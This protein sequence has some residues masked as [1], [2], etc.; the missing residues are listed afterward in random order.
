M[1]ILNIMKRDRI[2]MNEVEQEVLDKVSSCLEVVDLFHEKTV[3]N[4]Y[5]EY[6][7]LK[8]YGVWTGGLPIYVVLPFY[9]QLI[10]HLDPI[11]D[12]EEFR[13]I[14]GV[15]IEEVAQLHES[16]RLI[17][18]LRRSYERY[19]EYYDILFKNHV[20]LNNRFEKVFFKKDCDRIEIY[21]EIVWRRFSQQDVPAVLQQKVE[22]NLGKEK[23]KDIILGTMAQRL[24]KLSALGFAGIGVQ[25]IKENNFLKAYEGLHK[26]NRAFAVPIID[27]LGGW[28]NLD[29]K[30][31]DL[32]EQV[33]VE[34]E[35]SQ[36][37]LPR[38][39]L[40]WLNKTISYR[41]PQD[42]S[43]GLAFLKAVEEAD[44]VRENHN[45]LI[46][47]QRELL[48]SNYEA[49]Y[50][51]AKES[52]QVLLGLKKHISKIERQRGSLRRW[53][54]TPIRYA[55]SALS[56]IAFSLAAAQIYSG[57][58]SSA[59]FSG[60]VGTGAEII[61]AKTNKIEEFLTGL[62]SKRDSAA[63]MIWKKISRA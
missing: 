47:L 58:V 5:P 46:S 6:N 31:I 57:K 15:S 56:P 62:K 59:I 43:S 11:K 1:N 35:G 29:A 13:A 61:G 19:P 30:H 50:K 51:L 41:Y 49:G 3:I 32:V 52:K 14:Y 18:L 27:A 39:I 9:R 20:P 2:N 55:C 16:G 10:V 33:R 45:I 48:E 22:R 54:T 26:Y 38:D 28:D 53:V 8:P 24:V 4:L 37:L 44:E 42:V 23:S 21:R 17:L 25:I 7:F 63:F 36:L 34:K 12:P 60:V 40:F